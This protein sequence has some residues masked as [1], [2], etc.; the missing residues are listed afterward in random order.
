[1]RVFYFISE[2]MEYVILVDKKDKEIGIEEKIKAHEKCLLHRAFSILIFNSKYEM[3]LQK[4]ANSKYH[5]GGLWTNA[6]C[7]HP[8]PNEKIEDAAHRRLR[9]EMGFDCDLKEIGSFI[10]K[11]NF[12]NGLCEYE[13]DHVFLGFYDG[14][15]KINKDEA[16]E[17]KWVK[18]DDLKKDIKN[19]P[20]AYTPWFKIIM[21]KIRGIVC[22]KRSK[23]MKKELKKK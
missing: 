22:T 16:E 23:K 13:Y 4:R 3:L 18:L 10:Y 1:M 9:E 6:C 21:K 15:I 7:S 17:Y 8:R 2:K 12:E 19:N 11:A 5:C 20:E 14:K